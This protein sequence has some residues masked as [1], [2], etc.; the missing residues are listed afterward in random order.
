MVTRNYYSEMKEL[1]NMLLTFAEDNDIQLMLSFVP[2]FVELQK[3][4]ADNHD[5]LV[6]DEDYAKTNSQLATLITYV[7]EKIERHTEQTYPKDSIEYKKNMYLAYDA[8]SKAD[9]RYL[10][11]NDAYYRQYF[12]DRIKC[13]AL[14]LYEKE[15]SLVVDAPENVTA[16]SFFNITYSYNQEGKNFKLEESPYVRKYTGPLTSSSYS[17]TYHISYKYSCVCH[18]EGVYD[19]PKATIQINGET[20]PFPTKQIT[21]LPK[22]SSAPKTNNTTPTTLLSDKK[23]A[24]NVSEVQFQEVELHKCGHRYDDNVHKVCPICGEPNP[25]Y[26]KEKR[27][28][29]VQQFKSEILSK[30]AAFQMA[31]EEKIKKGN[32]TITPDKYPIWKEPGIFWSIAAAIA[33]IIFIVLLTMIPDAKHLRGGR[34]DFFIGGWMYFGG[35]LAIYIGKLLQGYIN[36]RPFNLPPANGA[37]PGSL[38]TTNNIGTTMLGG[39]RWVGGSCVSYEFVCFFIALFPI[40]CYRCKVGKTQKSGYKTMS[41]SYRFYGSEKMNG[42]EVLQIYLASW[43]WLPFLFGLLAMIIAMF[44]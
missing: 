43:G 5:A 7:A 39:F 6:N 1:S 42:L 3:Y 25:N 13:K 40:G 29:E 17:P 16:G 35:T 38:G 21:A 34:E 22:T 32:E 4:L 10:D 28:K 26:D 18:K 37:S 27:E 9:L 41:T 14:D 36:S 33:V 8:A 20:I 23:D 15:L 2:K 19:L 12:I 24:S 44:D 30:L 31:D 11:K